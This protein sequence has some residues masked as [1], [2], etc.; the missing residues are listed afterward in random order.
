MG[1]GIKKYRK[2]LFMSYPKKI[3]RGQG[4][5]DKKRRKPLKDV[6]GRYK[7]HR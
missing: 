7:N 3:E 1:K 2:A 4:K 5:N 6:L